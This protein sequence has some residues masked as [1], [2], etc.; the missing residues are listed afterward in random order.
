MARLS[1]ALAVVVAAAGMWLWPRQTETQ[2]TIWF[3]ESF[4]ELG[5]KNMYGFSN[6]YPQWNGESPG[7]TPG[8]TFAHDPNGGDRGAGDGAAH[9][10]M[11]AGHE[12]YTLGWVARLDRDW[13]EG[14]PNEVYA[15]FR[16][17]WDDDH[18]F[19]GRS[20]LQNKFILFGRARQSPESR[21]ILHNEMPAE[22]SGCTLGFVDYSARGRTL[23]Q[24]RDFGLP[25]GS[26]EDS[27]IAGLW[28]SLAM[29][30]NISWDCTPPIAVTV[31]RW[32]HV[33]FFVRSGYKNDAQFKMW[34]NNDRADA[35]STQKVGGFT[36]GTVAAWNE[37][38]I[39]GYMTNTPN[40]DGGYRLDDFEIGS[41]FDASWASSA[42]TP[43]EAAH[44]PR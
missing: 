19:T 8:W 42:G 37:W 44:Q 32:Y 11:R 4:E 41:I 20:P 22:T 5:P 21:F 28:G 14:Q 23:W 12:Q 38:N 3:Q 1:F 9:V 29:K 40:R 33:Q 16:I 36:F 26:W 15:R 6:R 39:G 2:S 10:R 24:P 17:R 30:A 13:V 25:H 43:P 27:K 34:V 18:R 35:P 7:Q 31:G